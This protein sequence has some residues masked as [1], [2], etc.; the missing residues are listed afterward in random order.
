MGVA[1]P[2]SLPPLESSQSALDTDYIFGKQPPSLPHSQSSGS[3]DL[4]NERNM[5]PADPSL[6]RNPGF[7][8]GEDSTQ[9][10]HGQFTFGAI[11]SGKSSAALGHTI[12]PRLLR[13]SPS[14][15]PSGSSASQLDMSDIMAPFSMSPASLL[16]IAQSSTIAGNAVTHGEG[17]TA[18]DTLLQAAQQAHDG[19]ASNWDIG[20]DFDFSFDFSATTP[21]SLPPGAPTVSAVPAK[22]ASVKVKFPS[23]HDIAGSLN[24]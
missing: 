5:S 3:A 18:V 1:D 13:K 17:M 24:C 12:D 22:N 14:A 19:N 15:A 23:K 6:A 7:V 10:S 20:A 8:F 16:A 4:A 2:L 11:S 21:T 9:A